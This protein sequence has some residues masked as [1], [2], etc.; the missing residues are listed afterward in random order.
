MLDPGPAVLAAAHYRR[1]RTLGITIRK[2]VDVII[3]TF[4]IEKGH[5]LLHADRDFEPMVRHLGLR[6]I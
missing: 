5:V 6:T 2:L 1:L 4:C 3:G